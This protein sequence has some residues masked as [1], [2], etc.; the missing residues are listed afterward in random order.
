MIVQQFIASTH[1]TSQHQCADFIW[2]EMTSL[3]VLVK[4]GTMQCVDIGR[5][6]SIPVLCSIRHRGHRGRVLWDWDGRNCLVQVALCGL[7]YAGQ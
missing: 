6:M 3:H 1:R 5:A 2:P 4:W 7:W